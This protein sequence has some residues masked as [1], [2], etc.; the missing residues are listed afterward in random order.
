[1]V[2]FNA[3]KIAPLKTAVYKKYDPAHD[4]KA[5]LYTR[6]FEKLRAIFRGE[7][8]IF[9]DFT[10]WRENRGILFPNLRAWWHGHMTFG[11]L[12]F[13]GATKGSIII[14][15]KGRTD[16]APTTP[17][18]TDTPSKTTKMLTPLPLPKRNKVGTT[19]NK[20]LI[21]QNKRFFQ[22]DSTTNKATNVGKIEGQRPHNF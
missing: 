3:E 2:E 9:A 12:L 4:G 10:A 16:P 14:T 5:V 1:M 18:T 20:S 17:A 15:E 11:Q 8:A 13:G 6:P 19:C 21:T 7:R 22:P